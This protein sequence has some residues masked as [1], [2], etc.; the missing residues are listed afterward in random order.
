MIK[1]VASVNTLT[2]TLAYSEGDK[3]MKFYCPSSFCEWRVKTLTTKEPFTLEWLKTLS[4]DDVLWDIGA[5]V[6][7]YT[8]YAGVMR[9]VKI[10]AFEPEA[11]NYNILNENVR[12]NKL[13]NLVTAFN[14]GVGNQ[15]KFTTLKIN[16]V[17]PGSSGHQLENKNSFE[18]T[19]GCIS[20]TIDK[21]ARIL[22]K[23]THIKIDVDGIEHLII[24]GGLDTIKNTKSLLVEFYNKNKKH[25]AAKELLESIGFYCDPAILEQT[26]KKP[27]EQYEGMGEYL[28]TR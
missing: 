28:F 3:I 15:N 20:Y 16:K 9:G 21:L 17:E 19:Q 13:S 6:G 8:I 11:S 4:E 26:V 25:M 12:L 10:Y 18:F 22:P 23:P 27:G 7:M 1:T 14:I 2:K 5:N 24:E